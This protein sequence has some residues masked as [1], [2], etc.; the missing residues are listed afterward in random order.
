MNNCQR[1]L[2]EVLRHLHLNSRF[3]VIISSNQGYTEYN[4]GVMLKYSSAYRM[5]ST[6]C[7]P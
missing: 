1:T 7:T 2:A 4:Q 6:C 3:Q 5:R